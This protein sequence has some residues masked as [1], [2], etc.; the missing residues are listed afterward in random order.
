MSLPSLPSLP[1]CCKNI[2]CHVCHLPKAAP[3]PDLFATI[4]VTWA[5]M[6]QECTN[7]LQIILDVIKG[8]S[9]SSDKVTLIPDMPVNELV[10]QALKE[11]SFLF[12]GKVSTGNIGKQYHVVSW[13]FASLDAIHKNLNHKLDAMELR[14]EKIIANMKQNTEACLSVRD[15]PQFIMEVLEASGVKKISTISYQDK[16]YATIVWKLE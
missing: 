16:L 15:S 2:C 11:C 6:S 13:N 10:K 12:S 1:E 9:A 5:K 14:L 8:H 4:R 3:E 7:Q